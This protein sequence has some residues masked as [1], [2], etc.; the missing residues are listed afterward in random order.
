MSRQTQPDPMS[1]I[2]L[3]HLFPESLPPLRAPYVVLAK[4]WK[5]PPE[6]EANHCTTTHEGLVSA[7]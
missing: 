3:N 5:P 7:D 1:V 4:R 6:A 2:P